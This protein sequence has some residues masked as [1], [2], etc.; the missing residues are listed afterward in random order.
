M[1]K[2]RFD[3]VILCRNENGKFSKQIKLDEK[4]LKNL[5]AMNLSLDSLICKA[6][7]F[8]EELNYLNYKINSIITNKILF[9]YAGIEFQNG[10]I[11]DSELSRWNISGVLEN[12]NVGLFSLI[13]DIKH[14]RVSG[15]PE[16]FYNHIV[17]LIL[18]YER[19]K[20]NKSFKKFIAEEQ[21]MMIENRFSDCIILF[22]KI[23]EDAIHFS[24]WSWIYNF[25]SFFMECYD[26]IPISENYNNLRNC[27]IG[28]KEEKIENDSNKKYDEKRSYKI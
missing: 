19:L 8:E 9:C 17:L 3:T 11:K 7:N 1:K 12:I 18:I 5:N 14:N 4:F 2:D 21:L 26:Y 24:N 25:C 27:V 6:G 20:E 22:N 13:N 15:D 10:D 23:I 16:V 28:Y